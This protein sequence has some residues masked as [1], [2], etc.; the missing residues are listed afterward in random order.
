[1]RKEPTIRAELHRF[2]A[3]SIDSGISL[4]DYK[5]SGLAVEYPVDSEKADLVVFY[6][7]ESSAPN[8]LLVIETK[9][10]VQY[11]AKTKP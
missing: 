11:P 6:Q 9:R 1:M 10:R 8:P 5:I 7:Y 2:L 3:N 4:E